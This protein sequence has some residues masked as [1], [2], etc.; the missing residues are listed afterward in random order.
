MTVI[1]QILKYLLAVIFIL[2][3]ISHFVM[4]EF[5]LRIMPPYLPAPLFLI[6]LSGFLETGF[7]IALLLPKYSRRAAWGI[8][9]LLI[10]VF[11]ANIYMATNTELFPD[12]NPLIIYLRLPLQFVLI[13]WA[14]WHTK[15]FGK[16]KM[17]SE[18]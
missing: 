16:L 14:F 6:Y 15:G 10:A 11:P 13:A 7:G 4:P 9:L 18:N 17:E 1:K 3:G 12:L 2:A 8:I 5:Y